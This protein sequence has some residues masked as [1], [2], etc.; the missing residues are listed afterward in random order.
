MALRILQYDMC[1]APLSLYRVFAIEE[2]INV[3]GDTNNKDHN[4]SE[5]YISS[6]NMFRPTAAILRDP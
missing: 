3:N 2:T 6:C 4:N 5:S 1:A